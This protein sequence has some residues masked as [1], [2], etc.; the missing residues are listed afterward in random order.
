MIAPGAGLSVAA[1]FVQALF[2][3]VAG[4][5]AY[6]S[7]QGLVQPRLRATAAAIFLLGLN[8]IGLGL[9]PVTVGAFNDALVARGFGEGPGLKWALLVV[10]EIVLVVGAGFI[11]AARQTFAADTVS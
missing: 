6:A 11:A 2:T 3:G 7:I 4:A 10:G 1:L 9:G 5:P 8:L